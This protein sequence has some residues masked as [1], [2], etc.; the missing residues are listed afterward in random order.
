MWKVRSEVEP[1]CIAESALVRAGRREADRCVEASTRVEVE[2]EAEVK[3][4]VEVVVVGAG[5]SEAR[6]VRRLR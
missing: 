4:V 3:V 2:V 1:A 5:S 6:G